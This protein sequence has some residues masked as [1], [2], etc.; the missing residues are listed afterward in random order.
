MGWTTLSGLRDEY[1][2]WHEGHAAAEEKPACMTT[3]CKVVRQW[4]D[5]IG[6]RK[7]SQ[8]ARQTTCN[9]V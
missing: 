6:F 2:L 3:F 8:R 1:T 5:K 9:A 7:I 4:R